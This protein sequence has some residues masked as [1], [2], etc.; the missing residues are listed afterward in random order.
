MGEKAKG[1][2]I[3]LAKV[4]VATALL[5]WLL[6]GG[7]LDLGALVVVAR[8]PWLL[9]T[10]FAMWAFVAVVLGGLRWRVLLTLA[11][12]HPKL[13]RVFSLQLVALFFNV[14]IPGNVG[15]D[16]LKALYVARNEDA[17]KR[18]PILVVVFVER[19]LGLSGL[20]A[21]ALFVTAVRFPTLWSTPS[22]RPLVMSVGLLGFG[23]VL[24]PALIVLLMR[25]FGE[26]IE[27]RLDGPSRLAGLA[28]KLVQAFRLMATRPGPLVGGMLIS[29]LMHGITV[30]WFALLAREIEGQAASFSAVATIYPLGVLTM[31]LPISPAGVGVGHAAFEKLFAMIGLTG[32]STVFNVF[33][34]GQ[35]I[36]C[37]IG[38]IPYVS[39]RS[40]APLSASEE[41]MEPAE[42]VAD[43][44]QP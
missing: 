10:N 42:P 14:V 36:P 5:T 31:I 3:L 27:A 9:A 18:A 24:V 4:L 43:P 7:N 44:S 38:A 22:L 25:R 37:T 13:S 33:L 29:I 2:L 20:V 28:R 17:D 35:I 8:T 6:R 39:L 12:A 40:K 23:F 30:A 34:V 11:G 16:V 21:L 41:T 26:R 1:R 32:G 19:M 15:G